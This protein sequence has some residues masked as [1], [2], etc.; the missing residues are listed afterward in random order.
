MAIGNIVPK[1]RPNQFI[2]KRSL[3]FKGQDWSDYWKYCVHCDK[4][5]DWYVKYNLID[6]KFIEVCK[7]HEKDV[8]KDSFKDR[9]KRY[10]G[11]MW[12]DV[13]KEEAEKIINRFN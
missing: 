13:T 4:S 10:H 8:S 12:V 9:F 1:K 7:N 2:T 3:W 6:S 11:N 5:L